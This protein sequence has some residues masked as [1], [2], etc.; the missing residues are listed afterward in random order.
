MTRAMRHRWVTRAH[1]RRVPVVR[2]RRDAPARCPLIT[3]SQM[4]GD[5]RRARHRFSTAYSCHVRICKT[6]ESVSRTHMSICSGSSTEVEYTYPH[7]HTPGD[8][9]AGGYPEMCDPEGGDG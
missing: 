2:G 8:C 6:E 7:C 9:G 1:P 4:A 3:C 5:G